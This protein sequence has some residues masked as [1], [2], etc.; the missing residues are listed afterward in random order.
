MK[1]KMPFSEAWVELGESVKDEEALRDQPQQDDRVMSSMER[2]ATSL[3]LCCR[4]RKQL[5][6]NQSS[7]GRDWA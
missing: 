7:A 3:V 1:T 6:S 5:L 4:E 2:E